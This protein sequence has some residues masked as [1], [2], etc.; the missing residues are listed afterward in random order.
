MNPEILRQS[1][2][3]KLAETISGY[4]FRQIHLGLSPSKVFRLEA[5]NKNSLYLKIAP[6]IPA[7][8][9]SDEK[10]KL[11]WLENRLPVP[12][13]LLFAEDE[14]TDYLLL[15][16][17]SGLPAGDDSL[18]TGIPRLIEQ[19][20]N[21]LK[22]I[23]SLPFEDCPFDL[24][25]DSV[26]EIVRERISKNLVDT[27]DFDEERQGR[28]AEDIFRELIETKPSSEDLVFTHGDY[29]VPNVILKDGK[30]NG[31]VD[32]G[33]AGIADKYQDIAL[34]MRSVKDNFGEEYEEKVFEIYGIEPDWEKIRFYKLLD[35]FF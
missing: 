28:T 2:P 6:R 27:S 8:S 22:M 1:L 23:H 13:V 17:I 31:F 16:E 10:L 26:I 19:L 15:S 35:E 34:L 20:V 25:V 32:L 7:F 30:L 12:E 3:L 5:A 14:S 24:R 21:G 33:N 9:L 11:E 18:Q 29:C 4:D